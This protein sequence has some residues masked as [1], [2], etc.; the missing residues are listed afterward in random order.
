MKAKELTLIIFY[1]A[2]LVALAYTFQHA[3]M[4]TGIRGISYFFTIF[5]A[6]PNVLAILS[7][8]GRRWR[9]LSMGCIIVLLVLPSY[10][11]GAPFDITKTIFI[12][13]FF[14]SDVVFNSCHK[15][16]ENKS[17]LLYWSVLFA[18]VFYLVKI[19]LS[20][21][22]FQLFFSPYVVKLYI[23]LIKGLVGVIVIEATVGA[24]LGY[25]IYQSIKVVL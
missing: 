20:L 8:R 12:V 2:V 13:P 15:Y 23:E 10:I 18:N 17:K 1:A 19:P 21:I 9:F 6:I 24:Y 22:R 25:K 16:F 14:F 7:F 4:V 5:G 11:H 3:R